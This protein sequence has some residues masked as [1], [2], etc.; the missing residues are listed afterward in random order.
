MRI[1]VTKDYEEISKRAA[2][3]VVGQIIE[4]PDSVIGLATGSTP[5]GM[6]EEIIRIHN[7]QKI[8]FSKVTSFNL[9]EYIGLSE[10]NENSYHHYMQ[11]NFFNL[12]CK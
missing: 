2:E 11:E 10:S 8:S 6:Y 1:I 4:K 12:N 7:E 9:D 3:L 5:R